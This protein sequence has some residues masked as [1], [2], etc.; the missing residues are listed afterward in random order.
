M[1]HDETPGSQQSA[2][3]ASPM[4]ATDAAHE[5]SEF[6]VI[7]FIRNGSS[8]RAARRDRQLRKLGRQTVWVDLSDND[9]G[10]M[11]SLG[12]VERGIERRGSIG[13]PGGCYSDA[14]GQS[15]KIPRIEHHVRPRLLHRITKIG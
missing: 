15:D 3:A 6:V 12:G 5:A 14:L 8:A 2:N 1:C 4:A 9:G 13:P 7:A 11:N 10:T